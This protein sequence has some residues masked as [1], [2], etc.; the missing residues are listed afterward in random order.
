L[1]ELHLLSLLELI[2]RRPVVAQ[3]TAWR[4]DPEHSTARL[5]LASS[6]NP[7]VNVNVGVARISGIA[8]DIGDDPGESVFDFTIYPADETAAPTRS[9]D[10]RSEQNA[11]LAA[12][13]TI[14]DIQVKACCPDRRRSVSRHGRTDVDVH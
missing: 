5:F 10:K 13:H 4:I 14:M 8:G 9:N 2:L 3:N 12:A 1:L 11:P 6:K 7:H